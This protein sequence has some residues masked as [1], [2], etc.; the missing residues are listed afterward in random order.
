[1]NRIILGRTG[2]E[3]S[4]LG[5]GAGGDS[6]LGAG[7]IAEA[8]SLRLVH[9]AIERGV[10]FIDTAEAYGT[11]A[12]LGKALREVPRER[13]VL[14]TKK[15]TRLDAPVRPEDVVSSLHASLER[16]G[17]DH[18]DVYHLHGVLPHHYADLRER[19]VPVL[20]RL[21]EQGKIRF[22][23]ITEA[24]AADPSHAMLEQAL[25]DDFWDVVM[26]GF[27]LLNQ[28]ARTS[29]F[30]LTRAKNVGTLIMFAVRRALSRPE[31]LRELL[32]D[33][34]ERGKVSPEL[35]AEGL[36]GLLEGEDISS[37]PDAAYR[38]C[39]DEPGAHVILSG[40]SS[41]AHLLENARS[42]DA[43]PLAARARE[44]LIEAFAR[45]D[46]VSGH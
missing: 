6:R 1:M 18:V 44:R 27:N 17:T 45:V 16:L 42:I 11:E 23:G 26:V 13:V 12:L 40:T 46:D 10:S 30:P 35:A 7:R 14:S 28:S 39:R 43:P 8:D 4:V 33:L 37:L 29:V 5:L 38:F 3:V 24:F 22:L 41:V 31:R 20:L 25:R 21:R 34:A 36:D 19:I 9:A 32:A 15:T 2:L